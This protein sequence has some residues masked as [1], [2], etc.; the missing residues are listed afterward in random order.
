[1]TQAE[2]AELMGTDDRTV[3]NWEQGR[4]APK[5]AMLY[6]LQQ[7]FNQS[8]DWILTGAEASAEPPRSLRDNAR[9]RYL[10]LMKVLTHFV[11]TYPE[12]QVVMAKVDSWHS[13][14]MR[15]T[16]AG[17]TLRVLATRGGTDESSTTPAGGRRKTKIQ[18][19]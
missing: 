18:Q 14:I 1:M 19:S 6:K 11:D 10:D 16:A 4:R 7:V 9:L 13:L 12:E 17:T 3:S 5:V 15:E 2:L 8:V